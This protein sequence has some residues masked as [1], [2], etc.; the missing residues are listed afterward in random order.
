MSKV[1][2]LVDIEVQDGK[3]DAFLQELKSQVEIIRS[4]A[5]CELIEIL[6]ND[7]RENFIHVW[8]IWSDRNSWDL[9]MANESS[10][11]WQELASTF[12]IGEKI[13]IMNPL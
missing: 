8:E 13:T 11:A 2:L 4:E 3:V 1:F 10:K 5:G 12:V 9:H 7:S 6:K